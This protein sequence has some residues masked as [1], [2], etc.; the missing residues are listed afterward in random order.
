MAGADADKVT[1]D[2]ATGE[3]ADEALDYA[4]QPS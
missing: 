4:A 3:V 2:L 1:V